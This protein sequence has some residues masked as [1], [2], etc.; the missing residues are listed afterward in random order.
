MPGNPGSQLRWNHKSQIVW[1]LKKKRP[2]NGSISKTRPERVVACRESV[3][4]G[5]KMTH[6]TDNYVPSNSGPYCTRQAHHY[7]RNP[8]HYVGPRGRHAWDPKLGS[9]LIFLKLTILILG[10]AGETK[11]AV[12]WRYIVS[13]IFSTFLHGYLYSQY[14]VCPR[15]I[16]GNNRRFPSCRVPAC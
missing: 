12:R 1:G 10:L 14:G 15:P 6:L 8:Q 16:N 2:R 5:P 9:G 13:L 3:Q 7:Y 11:S 4:N